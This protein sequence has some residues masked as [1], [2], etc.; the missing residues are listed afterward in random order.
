MFNRVAPRYDFL[1]RVLSAGIDGLWR[2]RL[3]RFLSPEK[4]Q[5]VLDL[6]TGTGDQLLA[7]F[8]FS[9]RVQSAVGIDP[10]ERMLVIAQ[11]KIDQ[12]GLSE[13]VRLTTGNA[14][15]I[16]A[17][18]NE[19]DA[20]TISFGIRN[21]AD[22][23]RSLREVYRVLKP[24][25]RFLVLEFSL[26]QERVV[27]RFYLLYLRHLLPRVGAS[28]SGDPFAYRYLNE[29]IETFPYGERFCEFLREAG[30]Q[31]IFARPLALGIATI[32]HGRRPRSRVENFHGNEGDRL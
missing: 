6:A 19:F 21:V 20:V 8:R 28:I 23:S 25:G 12:A 13:A 10:A 22:V 1:N 3:V 24:G 18:D 5:H 29:T 9:N 4:G 26:P 27:R 17:K 7:M 16:P 14:V 2:R 15:E 30:F 31:N 11:R 32:Y